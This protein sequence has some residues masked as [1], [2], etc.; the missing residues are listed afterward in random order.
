MRACMSCGSLAGCA[1][2]LTLHC[3]L[4]LLLLA[5]RAAA[6]SRHRRRPTAGTCMRRGAGLCWSAG[7]L[8]VAAPGRV[9]G[10]RG[11]Q[12][13]VAACSVCF[14]KTCNGMG[15]CRRA[16]G[17]VHGVGVLARHGVVVCMHPVYSCY[18]IASAATQAVCL[19]TCNVTMCGAATTLLRRPW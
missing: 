3:T 5:L 15:E 6:A 4:L 11:R 18:K 19:S 14:E 12:K 1:A 9:Y 17:Q 8:A 7:R 16:D 10:C 13:L 2:S